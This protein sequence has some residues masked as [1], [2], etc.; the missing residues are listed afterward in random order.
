MSLPATEISEDEA[1]DDGNFP[2]KAD[3][4]TTVGKGKAKKELI[5]ETQEALKVESD[6]EEEEE[7]KEDDDDDAE[8]GPDE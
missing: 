3:K 6:V 2:V 4:A 8:Q 7:E 1:S 5:E